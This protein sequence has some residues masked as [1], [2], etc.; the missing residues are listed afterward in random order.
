MTRR[1]P[2][3]KTPKV[4]FAINREIG[5]YNVKQGITEGDSFTIYPNGRLLSVYFKGTS[6]LFGEDSGRWFTGRD[7]TYNIRKGETMLIKRDGYYLFHR[8]DQQMIIYE[9]VVVVKR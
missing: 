4:E 1:N 8:L 9:A 5:V 2:L 7:V 3:T 6:A